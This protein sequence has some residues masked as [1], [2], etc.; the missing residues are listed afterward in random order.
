[1]LVVGIMLGT[2][3]YWIGPLSGQGVVVTIGLG[4]FLGVLGVVMVLYGFR[5]RRKGFDD[6]GMARAGQDLADKLVRMVD[7]DN[8]TLPPR[9]KTK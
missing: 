2:G 5:W 1:M 9:A 7:K 4:L 3:P 6:A 8:R